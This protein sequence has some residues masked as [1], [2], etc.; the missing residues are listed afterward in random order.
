MEPARWRRCLSVIA[1]LGVLS[2][3]ALGPAA[4][5]AQELTAAPDGQ[6]FDKQSVTTQNDFLATFGAK[7]AQQEWVWQHTLAVAPDAFSGDPASDGQSFGDQDDDVQL[8]FV[9]LFGPQASAQWTAEH[10]AVVAHRVLLKDVASVPCPPAKTV[11]GPMDA[12]PAQ[13]LADAADAAKND[14]LAGATDGFAAFKV[15]WATA[16]PKVNAQSAAVAQ[17]VQ[18]AVDQVSA[19]AGKADAQDQVYPALQ[20]LLKVVKGANQTLAGQVH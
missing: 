9:A 8:P 4:A 19:L 2:A 3:L 14:N 5:S 18:S 13:H 20:N 12:I 16:K 7:C 10:N 6:V 17:S 15:I 1:S 11:L